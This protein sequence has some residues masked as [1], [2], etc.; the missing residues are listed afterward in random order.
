[1]IVTNPFSP[2]SLTRE[3]IN[4]VARGWWVLML[5][6]IV[7]VV[8]GGIIL[9]TDWTVSQLVTFVGLLFI[10]RGVLTAVSLPVDGSMRSWAVAVG[11]LEVGIGIGVFTWPGPTLLVLALMI[12]WW[13]LFSGIMTTAGAITARDFLPYWGLMLAYGIIETL[14]A[15]WLIARPDVTLV[16]TILAIGLWTMVYGVVQVILSFE[17]KNL[18][19]RLG[20]AASP[21]TSTRAAA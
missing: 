13:V 9:F 18:P 17:L 21:V 16:A 12:G 11:L 7:G 19:R 6:G 14:F 10:F 8:A 2:G 1:M 3:T 20:T 15:F 5:S 4:T